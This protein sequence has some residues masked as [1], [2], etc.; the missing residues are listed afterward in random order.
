MSSEERPE[1]RRALV[2]F[3]KHPT[4]GRVKTRLSPSLSGVEAARLYH[5]FLQDAVEIACRIPASRYLAVS[6]WSKAAWF[7]ALAA[8]DGLVAQGSGGLGR[9]LARVT[10]ARFRDGASAVVVLGSD[11]P[12]LPPSFVESA[13]LRLEAGADAVF[14]PAED[15]GYYLVGLGRPCAPLFEGVR[16]SG[17]ETLAATLAAA[18]RERLRVELLPPWYDVD[19]PGD[20]ARL[21]RELERAE[22][23]SP[24][25][26][27][28]SLL[29][30]VPR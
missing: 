10:E 26:H 3:A 1:Q 17:P 8:D 7:R 28:A 2:V 22:G 29:G 21:R 30:L 15:G 14:G 9:R 4:P 13:F 25:P 5:A 6:P 12:T 16:F 20:L 18:V 24:A 23:P 27:T 11:S 19:G